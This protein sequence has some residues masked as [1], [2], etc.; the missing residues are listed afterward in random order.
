MKIISIILTT[1]ICLLCKAQSIDSIKY[2][3]EVSTEFWGS[4]NYN[5]F[6]NFLKT[7][8]SCFSLFVTPKN[9]EKRNQYNFIKLSPSLDTTYKHFVKFTHPLEDYLETGK[10][11]YTVNSSKTTM[12]KPDGAYLSKYD[13]S[14]AKCWT[15]KIRNS[16]STD[17]N[18][19]LHQATEN[20]LL[21]VTN[22]WY[23]RGQYL[24]IEKRN[25]DGKL[26]FR[27]EI[28]DK[29]FSQE[30]FSI[31]ELKDS[32]LIIFTNLYDTAKFGERT[33]LGLL[34]LN[35]KG[36][37]IWKKIFSEMILR[38]T[39]VTKEE[40]IVC[41]GK[42]YYYEQDSNYDHHHL[43]VIVINKEGNLKWEK[44]IK[45][46]RYDDV[47]SVAETADGNLI[48]SS[49][50]NPK[51]GWIQKIYL[52]E[53]NKQGN[54][55]YEKNLDSKSTTSSPIF[56]S[57]NKEIILANTWYIPNGFEAHTSKIQFIKL[58]K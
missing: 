30:M 46:T 16:A 47:G 49:T 36:D 42:T 14:W 2:K 17:D 45:K 4:T 12:G 51:F 9:N 22:D 11:F 1:F 56:K 32:S 27:K 29:K 21:L 57:I 19:L 8:D 10:A 28:I 3:I 23:G 35:K 33:Y 15:K 7:K 43:K 58:S 18:Y 26:L 44:E 41:F 54:I 39:L 37:L 55:V 20:E 52:F 53:L 5:W 34:K 40:D 48:F 25:L 6:S 38:Q 50:I 31:L 13:K 24:A